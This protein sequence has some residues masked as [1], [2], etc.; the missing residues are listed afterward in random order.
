MYRND[1]DDE[2]RDRPFARRWGVG[3]PKYFLEKAGLPVPSSNRAAGTYAAILLDA[4][5]LGRCDRERWLSYSR[6]PEHYSRRCRYYG[7]SSYTHVVTGVDS[8]LELGFL[9][10][11]KA[12]PGQLGRQSSFRASGA[13]LLIPP[14]DDLAYDPGELIRLR[15]A[16]KRL[17]D[18]RETAETYRTCNASL[19]GLPAW[20]TIG[21]GPTL[22]P[23]VSTI[24]EPSPTKAVSSAVAN[25]GP[26]ALDI[27]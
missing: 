6:R 1:D 15:D 27:A 20:S 23:I 2:G 10:H 7:G 13:L 5:A 14:P 25:W 18:Y 21:T 9:E 12:V 19:Y 4:M 24:S 11:R 22:T 3:D 17:A 16:E 8:F 26:G